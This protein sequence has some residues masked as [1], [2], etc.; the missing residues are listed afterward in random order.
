[1]AINIFMKDAHGIRLTKMHKPPMVAEKNKYG[2]V[3]FISS[4]RERGIIFLTKNDT[5]TM[6]HTEYI[7]V[8]MATQTIPNGS[9]IKRMA[10]KMD[11]FKISEYNDSCVF[12]VTERIIVFNRI[13]GSNI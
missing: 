4:M 1:M 10:T 9:E 8:L 3:I 11:F 13:I 7:M 5:T 12:P 6:S 2:T